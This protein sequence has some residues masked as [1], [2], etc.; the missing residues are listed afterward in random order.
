MPAR[1]RSTVAPARFVS[2]ISNRLAT[3]IDGRRSVAVELLIGTRRALALAVDNW[4][5][6]RGQRRCLK[7]SIVPFAGNG[8]SV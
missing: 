6:L 4:S 7:A 3:V 1:G 5:G 8:A 2:V